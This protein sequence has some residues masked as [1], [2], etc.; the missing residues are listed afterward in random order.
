MS[1]KIKKL[2]EL[3]KGQSGRIMKIDQT[4]MKDITDRMMQM[5][6]IEGSD[7]QVIHEAPFGGD[8]IAVRARGALIALRRSE[9]N[10]L[11]VLVDE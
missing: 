9:A 7:V 5:G 2:G 10:L 1:F 6:L 3:Q 4:Q 11:E 8:P